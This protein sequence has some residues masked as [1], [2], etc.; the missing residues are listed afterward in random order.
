[1]KI[2][3]VLGPTSHNEWNVKYPDNYRNDPVIQAW[4]RFDARNSEYEI[5]GGSCP[6]PIPDKNIDAVIEYEARRNIHNAGIDK[7]KCLKVFHVQDTVFYPDW[8]NF[9]A[10]KFDLIICAQR[11]A[12]QLIKH[13]NKVFIPSGFDPFKM[14]KIDVIPKLY[15]IGLITS[16]RDYDYRKS[17]LEKLLENI[18]W[19]IWTKVNPNEMA[20]A[21]NQC[22]MGLNV[23][24]TGTED[25]LAYRICE[26]LACGLL[27]IT[28]RLKN[29]VLEE[30]YDEGV[31][32][33]GY[34][35]G[36]YDEFVEKVK[37]VKENKEEAEEIRKKGYERVQEFTWDKHVE[38]IVKAINENIKA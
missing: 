25:M 28:D 5:V 20:F 7:M 2:L 35:K 10:P 18:K 33:L 19:K 24:S 17:Y 8:H 16:P 4:Q 13:S 14:Q 26:T 27:L 1:M 12:E 31:H 29:N 15:D 38:R 36:N 22:Y 23:S 34:E 3:V 11:N 6:A 37:W 32:Y 21:L 30:F 9:L